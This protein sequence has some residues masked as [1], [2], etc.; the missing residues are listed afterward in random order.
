MAGDKNAKN[1]PPR[2]RGG[3]CAYSAEILQFKGTMLT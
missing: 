2:D 3:L 1:R